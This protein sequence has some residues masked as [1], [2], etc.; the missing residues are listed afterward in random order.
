MLT[1]VLASALLGLVPQQTS[2]MPARFE[3]AAPDLLAAVWST[4]SVVRFDGATGS[5]EGT[6]T[7]GGPLRL[8]AGLDYGPDGNLYVS[9]FYWDTVLEY[10]GRTGAYVGTFVPEGSG[11][12]NQPSLIEFR[13]DGFLYVLSSYDGGLVRYDADTGAFHDVFI[14]S[15]SGGITVAFAMTFGP[16][17]DVY[18]GGY[19]SHEVVRFDGVTGAV[20]GVVAPFV[21]TP[22]GMA[23][24][25][26]GNLLVG[27][28]RSGSF[29]DHN[30]QR[31]SPGGAD[32]GQLTELASGPLDFLVDPAGRLFIA[33]AGSIEVL[34]ATTGA[35]LDSMF[36]PGIENVM[37]I[38]FM[39]R[40]R[41]LPVR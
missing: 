41:T 29:L 7:Q 30:V 20:K 28:W 25:P 17:G 6:F 27:E 36:H 24:G 35:W 37:A 15:G 1:A 16:D 33:S 21:N 38:E 23:F 22:S 8:P 9:S 11:G 31:Y 4:N 18:L 12:L 19:Y 26:D 32:L 39:P 14:P 13:P 5:Y 2:P 3:P 40:P 10:D 34:D